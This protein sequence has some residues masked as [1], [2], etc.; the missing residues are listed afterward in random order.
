MVPGLGLEP[1]RPFGQRI[2]RPLLDRPR[3]LPTGRVA[4]GHLEDLDRLESFEKPL[5]LLHL[6]GSIGHEEQVG[7]VSA[8]QSGISLAT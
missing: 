3:Q 5:H 4:G 1:G 6:V 2:L 7:A 8:V